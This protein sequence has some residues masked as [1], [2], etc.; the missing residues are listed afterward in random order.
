M[1]RLGRFDSEEDA[2]RAY[3]ARAEELDD[4]RVLNFLADGSLNPDRKKRS[5]M[6]ARQRAASA[7]MAEE[8]EQTVAVEEE[9]EEADGEQR[10]RK[11]GRRWTRGEMK[12]ED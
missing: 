3:D 8:D 1:E 11:R 2:A 9:K 4:L 7:A 12:K 6:A 10:P 5:P